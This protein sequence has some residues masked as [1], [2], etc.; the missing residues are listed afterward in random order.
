MKMSGSIHRSAVCVFSEPRY[1]RYK[2]LSLLAINPYPL[3]IHYQLPIFS[4]QT[5]SPSLS[6][7]QQHKTAIHNEDCWLNSLHSLG[8]KTGLSGTC[9][10]LVQWG[11][12]WPITCWWDVSIV[13]CRVMTRGTNAGT[14]KT[15]AAHKS[16]H[17]FVVRHSKNP[18]AHCDTGADE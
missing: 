15:Y 13:T 18:C 10:Q 16:A 9:A 2:Y 5:C 4:I 12:T 8:W 11:K 3:R 14:E 1:P 7:A 6:S 17:V